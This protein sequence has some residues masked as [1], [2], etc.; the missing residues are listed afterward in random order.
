M[1]EPFFGIQRRPFSATPDSSCFFACASV[2]AALDELIVCVERGQG[3]GLLVSPA[4]MGKTLLCQ[5]LAA[6]VA[7]QFEAVCLGSSTFP[8]RRSLLQAILFEMGDDY[9]RKDESELRLDLRSR[10]MSLRPEKEA[11]VLIVDEAHLLADELLEEIR[12]LSDFADSGS[13]L[14]RIILTGQ[15]ELEERLTSRTFD[16]LNQRIS[17]QVYLESLTLTESRDYLAHRLEW[18]GATLDAVFAPE[19][20]DV[21]AR[22]S[23]GV[24]RCLNQLADHCLLLAFASDEKPV[25]RQTALD[26]LED[27]KQLPLHWNDVS[28]GES[29]VGWQEDEDEAHSDELEADMKLAE[30]ADAPP[31]MSMPDD[32]S[33]FEQR[34]ESIAQDEMEEQ[35]LPVTAEIEPAVIEFG[36]PVAEAHSESGAAEVFETV[37]EAT[38]SIVEVETPADAEGPGLCFEITSD[39]CALSFE[40][41]D[42]STVE[43]KEDVAA[44]EATTESAVLET[45]VSSPVDHSEGDEVSVVRAPESDE[46]TAPSEVS[47]VAET[48][49]DVVAIE[50]GDTSPDEPVENALIAGSEVEGDDFEEEVVIDHYSAIAEPQSTGIIWNLMQHADAATT[51]EADNTSRVSAEQTDHGEHSVH[52][53]RGVLELFGADESAAQSEADRQQI[54]AESVPDD[55]QESPVEL[56]SGEPQETLSIMAAG[57]ADQDSSEDVLSLRPD[58]RIDAI[59]PLLDEIGGDMARSQADQPERSMLDIEAELVQ[60]V[61]YGQPDIENEIGVAIL[62]MCLDAQADIQEARDRQVS[63]EAQQ[64][65]SEEDTF[66]F[67]DLSDAESEFTFD[68]GPF[69]IVEPE[70]E[71]LSSYRFDKPD[72]ADIPAPSSNEATESG[73]KSRP[74]GRLFSEL[75]RRQRH[76][77]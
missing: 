24:A 23:D 29:V 49:P 28:S 40:S 60:T 27:L 74:F 53:G 35:P 2:Q 18:S 22:A 9:S 72:V 38:E 54:E 61:E 69:D 15:P 48:Q 59:V 17:N 8:T 71:E 55:V 64:E 45:S 33:V 67:G 30:V 32:D 14:V 13:P 43:T 47:P 77:G 19:S 41:R 76:A 26:A 3:I 56:E 37:V 75:R 12:T 57:G 66:D 6:E 70:E 11:V 58:D 25:Q 44:E 62:D 5:R 34:A 10:L 68:A 63:Q 39:G 36:E 31:H 21:I 7:G 16:A 1:Y 51:E 42:E 46:I 4:G 20:I 52:D 73:S 50:S 65:A